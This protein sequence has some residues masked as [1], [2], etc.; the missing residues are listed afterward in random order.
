MRNQKG[1]S[2][3]ELMVVFAI[4]GVI[5]AIMVPM[6]KNVGKPTIVAE[7]VNTNISKGYM[8]TTETRCISGYKFILSQDGSVEQIL[9]E[10]GGGIRCGEDNK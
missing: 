10:Q 6:F 7:T 3:V 4:I 1:F 2:L 8:G 9:N 5:A